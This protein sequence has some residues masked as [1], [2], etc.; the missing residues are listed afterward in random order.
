MIHESQ[1][2]ELQESV[3]QMLADSELL[4]ATHP[5]SSRRLAWEGH[6]EAFEVVLQLLDGTATGERKKAEPAFRD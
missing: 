5:G 4:L 3:L 6:V 1:I 2:Y